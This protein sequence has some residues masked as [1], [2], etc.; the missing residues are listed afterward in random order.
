MVTDELPQGDL[1]FARDVLVHISSSNIKRFF[2]NCKNAGYKYL[3]TTTFPEV[4]NQELG[5]ILGGISAWLNTGKPG[6][7]K[8]CLATLFCH[9]SH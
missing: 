6:S 8:E 9:C 3:L 4:A 7:K 5:G 1:V 2:K